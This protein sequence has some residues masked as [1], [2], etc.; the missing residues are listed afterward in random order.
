MDDRPPQCPKPERL[1]ELIA[2]FDGDELSQ[3]EL[4]E[5][6]EALSWTH[7]FLETRKFHHRKSTLKNTIRKN[8]LLEAFPESETE[9]TKL[10]GK[11]AE[12][13]IINS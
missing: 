2:R 10:A 5:V 9:V 6:Q 7:W 12:D 8:L 3:E 11:A 13:E 4:G 1:E